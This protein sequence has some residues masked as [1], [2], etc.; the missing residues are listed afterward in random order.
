MNEENALKWRIK[1]T[2]NQNVYSFWQHSTSPNN[3]EPR[4]RL[5]SLCWYRRSTVG[6]CGVWI[7]ITISV[8]PWRCA[9]TKHE[10]PIIS[11]KYIIEWNNAWFMDRNKQI[12]FCGF[13]NLNINVVSGS[14]K[15]CCIQI[16][17]I[18]F[19]SGR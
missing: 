19:S 4:A 12:H 11:T 3:D 18:F 14:Y 15:P 2:K 17:T 10:P 5:A 6:L 8:S 16:H 9:I 1:D 13:E 7:I